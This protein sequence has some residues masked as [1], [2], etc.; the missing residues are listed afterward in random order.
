MARAHNCAVLTD[1]LD[2]YIRLSH[3]KVNVLNFTHL[4]E[5]AWGG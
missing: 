5:Q 1:D 2:L 4:R 3:D